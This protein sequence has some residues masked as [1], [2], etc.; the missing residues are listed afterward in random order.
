MV[1]KGGK[2]YSRGNSKVGGWEGVEE[3]VVVRVGVGVEDP[4]TEERVVVGV[5]V[6]GSDIV[7]REEIRRW[8]W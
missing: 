5:G 4:P 2:L 7:D 8:G 3:V 6:C 1:K